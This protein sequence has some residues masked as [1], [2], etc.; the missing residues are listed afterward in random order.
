MRTAQ[1]NEALQRVLGSGGVVPGKGVSLATLPT[2]NDLNV[3]VPL[4][5]VSLMF[6]NPIHIWREALPAIRVAS[7]KDS[8]RTFGRDSWLIPRAGVRGDG[9]GPRGGYKVSTT[10]Y[11]TISYSMATTVTDR[12]RNAAQEGVDDPDLNATRHCAD[13]TNLGIEQL[14]RDVVFA[15][16]NYA[17]T[18]TPS[19]TWDDGASDPIGDVQTGR[20][21]VQLATGVPPN[22]GVMGYQVWEQLRDHPDVIARFS[23]TQAGIMTPELVAQVFDLDKLLIGRAIKVSSSEGAATTTTGFV[24]DKNMALLRVP[25]GAALDVPSFGYT[26]IWDGEDFQTEN[27]RNNGETA[28]WIRTRVSVDPLP[29]STVSGYLLTSAVA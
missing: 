23:S 27:W 11:E 10:N 25:D 8:I 12:E 22:V 6:R 7:A 3:N 15:T 13:Q 9:I 24:W 1:G 14:V 4:T 19:T 20:E 16:G 21:T 18:A 2:A 26:L 5:N 17:T 29:L 28:D